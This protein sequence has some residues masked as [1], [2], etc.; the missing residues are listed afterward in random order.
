MME[1]SPLKIDAD[2]LWNDL[3]ELSR[4][5]G[6]SGRGVARLALSD[7]DLAARRWFRKRMEEVGLKVKE[8][9]AANL[10]GRLEPNDISPT[11]PCVAFGSHID[12]VLAG[13]KFDGALG[14][15][16]GLEVM[17]VIQESGVRL[18]NPLELLVFTDEEGSHYAGTFG[19][20]AM[21]GMVKEEELEK[22][23]KEGKPT[24]AQDLRRMGKD[25]GQIKQARR[26]PTEFKAFLELHIEQGPVLE[27]KNIP[28]GIVEGIAHLHRYLIKVKGQ[29][30]HAGTTPMH[31]RDDALIKAAEIIIKVHQAV[32]AGGADLVGTIGE[33]QVYPGAINIIPGEVI[34][35]LDLRSSRR[36]KLDAVCQNIKEIISSIKNSVLEPILIKEGVKMDSP[37]KEII[38]DSCHQEGIAFGYLWS[39]A[40]HDA[41]TFPLLHIPAGMIFIPCKEGKSHCPE[42]EISPE[43]GFLGTLVLAEAVRRL[44]S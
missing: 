41:M 28:I 11:A 38:A 23:R 17:R 15:C 32:Q 27:T 24:L 3:M 35:S 34:M 33:I 1:K 7:A 29:A 26:Q 42:E 9:A 21:L 37:I 40:G 6:E 36:D 16:A 12:T 10:I 43:H 2:R 19:S 4:F 20:R 18:A 31:L 13:G 22:S 14:I 8:D 30:G 25:P 5:G 44:A 39:G